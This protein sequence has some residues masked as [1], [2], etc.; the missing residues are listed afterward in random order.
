LLL[1][2]QD[3]KKITLWGPQR[4]PRGI[5]RVKE[6]QTDHKINFMNTK[7]TWHTQQRRM[8]RL[9]LRLQLCVA[10]RH[11]GSCGGA[12]LIHNIGIGWG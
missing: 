4:T 7:R 10:W 8:T 3:H 9:H 1:L 12:P 6:S 2:R 11:M 5:L